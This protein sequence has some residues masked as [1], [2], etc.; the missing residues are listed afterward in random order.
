MVAPLDVMGLGRM[1]FFADPSG[2]MFGIWQAQRFGGFEL[3]PNAVGGRCWTELVTEDEAEAKPFY[4]RAFGWTPEPYMD[5]I[6]YTLWVCGAGIAGG[7]TSLGSALATPGAASRWEVI[8][9]VEDCDDFV[10]HAAT[11]GATVTLEP[12][13]IPPGRYA[14]LLDPLGGSFQVIKLAPPTV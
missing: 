2:A 10:S 8:F 5:G 14:A 12:T 7:M 9:A 4:H 13:D 3:P 11:L 6:D 1:G